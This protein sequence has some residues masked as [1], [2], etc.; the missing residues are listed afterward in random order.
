MYVSSFPRSLGA[1]LA[2]VLFSGLLLTGCLPPSETAGGGGGETITRE[3]IESFDGNGTA[4]EIIQALEPTWFS[5]RGPNSPRPAV[6]VNDTQQSYNA[7]NNIVA[8]DVERIV[9]LKPQQATTRFGQ[10]NESGA[11]VV[12]TR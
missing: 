3:D 6:Y 10:G 1:V 7:L 9:R 2:T 5:S 11:I 8:A 4:F 12:Y